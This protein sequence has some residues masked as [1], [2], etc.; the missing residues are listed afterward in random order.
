MP[1]VTVR[2]SREN[3]TR[4]DVVNPGG[5]ELRF[6]CDTDL[7]AKDIPPNV[8]VEMMLCCDAGDEERLAELVRSVR[9]QVVGER[10]VRHWA[11]EVVGYHG[12]RRPAPLL[13]ALPVCR[14]VALIGNARDMLDLIAGSSEYRAQLRTLALQIREL[15]SLESLHDFDAL[16]S[17]EISCANNVVPPWDRRGFSGFDALGKIVLS[18]AAT[19]VEYRRWIVQRTYA[20][21]LPIVFI[22]AVNLPTPCD[23]PEIGSHVRF[24]P[25]SFEHARAHWLPLVPTFVLFTMAAAGGATEFELNEECSAPELAA[26][27]SLRSSI[28]EL[29]CR[30]SRHLSGWW[31]SDWMPTEIGLGGCSETEI[32]LLLPSLRRLRGAGV[33]VDSVCDDFVQRLERLFGGRKGLTTIEIEGEVAARL[34]AWQWMLAATNSRVR[35]ALS[36][37]VGV[38]P[39][40]CDGCLEIDLGQRSHTALCRLL[41]QQGQVK[42]VSE[43]ICVAGEISTAQIDIMRELLTAL[44]RVSLRLAVQCLGGAEFA[45]E[46][47]FADFYPR[48]EL[49][50][51]LRDMLLQLDSEKE[52]Y[53]RVADW[54]FSGGAV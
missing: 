13:E 47:F 14:H 54:A 1:F 8:D 24:L 30:S 27:L 50:E 45:L 29:D 51:A 46:A 39:S 21:P 49:S 37:T 15:R 7:V 41:A 23:D 31:P 4:P 6:D 3:D 16:E 40:I 9:S 34:H 42:C 2:W 10:E 22:G 36:G 48:V 33:E 28:A 20:R 35:L 18:S 11:L 32:K 19:L 44:P 38:K 25:D 53:R 26:V 17:I 43:R 5:C 52:E 12:Q